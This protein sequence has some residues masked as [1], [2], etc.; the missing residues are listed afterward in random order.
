[1]KVLVMM[2]KKDRRESLVSAGEV[3][4]KERYTVNFDKPNL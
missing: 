4:Y 3:E 2:N 1:M